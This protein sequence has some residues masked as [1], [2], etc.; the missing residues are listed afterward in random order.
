MKQLLGLQSTYR[1]IECGL[2]VSENTENLFVDDSLTTNTW[3]GKIIKVYYIAKMKTSRFWNVLLTGLK[4]ACLNL[5]V[6]LMQQCR[7][8]ARLIYM[9]LNF[10]TDYLT[11]FKKITMYKFNV[12][13]GKCFPHQHWQDNLEILFRLP[14]FVLNKIM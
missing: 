11:S 7:P 2:E 9:N 6:S 3:H 5:D 10:N 12:H 14:N 13:Y 1:E 8:I 4:N